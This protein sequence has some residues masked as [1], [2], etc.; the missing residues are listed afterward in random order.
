MAKKFKPNKL[1]GG[2]S[3]SEIARNASTYHDFISRLSEALSS[4]DF[5]L[6]FIDSDEPDFQSIWKTYLFN[7][8]IKFLN[9]YNPDEIRIID[10]YSLHCNKKNIRTYL[11]DLITR[12]LEFIDSQL[13]LNDSIG[14][15][16]SESQLS[17]SL[18]QN[19]TSLAYIHSTLLPDGTGICK[20]D[21]TNIFEL[22]NGVTFN[23]DQH[24]HINFINSQPESTFQDS[25]NP[26]EEVLVRQ[27]ITR[28][29][30]EFSAKPTQE[31]AAGFSYAIISVY[32]ILEKNE[33]MPTPYEYN[34]EITKL[35]RQT[36]LRTKL[37][38]A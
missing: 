23:V 8:F 34:I 25:A 3:N 27:I 14:L 1:Q 38:Y 32:R 2:P 33:S 28:T 15:R 11:I 4:P 30:E 18:F 35:R 16:I 9:L 24:G 31:L 36:G 22:A 21:D 5:E 6:A 12:I 19:L 13:S 7:Y 20:L 29:L 17:R 26:D 10:S 37:Y